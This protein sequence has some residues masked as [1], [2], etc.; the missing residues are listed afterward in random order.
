M[1]QVV[2]SLL[3]GYVCGCFLTAYF[4]AKRFAGKDVSE[5]GSGNP[6]MANIICNVG[7]FPGIMVLVGDITKT[8]IAMGLA[9]YFFGETIWFYSMLFAGFGVLLGHNFPVWRKFKGGKGVAVTCAWIIV[10]M[11]FGGIASA[12][13]GGIIV[14]LTGLLP[15]GAVAIAVFAI[16]F[17]FIEFGTVAGVVMILSAVIMVYRNFPGFIRGFLNQEERKFKRERHIGNTIGTVAVIIVIIVLII[18][19]YKLQIN[20]P[21]TVFIAN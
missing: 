1:T 17:G 13:A 14:L 4:I 2:L 8:I 5:I 21:T 19:D 15:L 11:P 12:V 3:I 9:Y 16:P 7:K 20:G 6:G 18:V 10:L